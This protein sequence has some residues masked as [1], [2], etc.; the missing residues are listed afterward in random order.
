MSD[1]HHWIDHHA[2]ALFRYALLQVRDREA[3]QD[4]VQETFLAALRAR[5]TFRG[6]SSQRT[7]LVGIL[8]H[9]IC[10]HFRRRRRELPAED[11]ASAA[12]AVDAMFRDDGV[13]K[14]APLKWSDPQDPLLR[15][16]LWEQLR[17]CLDKMPPRM[18]DLLCLRELHGLNAG[19]IC[20]IMEISQTN[21]WV[22]LHRARAMLRQCL[23]RAWAER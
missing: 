20:Q 14:A 3:A 17:H 23:E 2:E 16:E 21:L 12:G 8:K 7:W 4:C 6:E 15:E 22:Q 9:K 5:E 19:E 10:D 18:G 13:W 11:P 1:P